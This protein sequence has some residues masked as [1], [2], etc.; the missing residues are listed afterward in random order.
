MLIPNLRQFCDSGYAACSSFDVASPCPWKEK[1]AKQDPCACFLASLKKTWRESEKSS[2][3]LKHGELV[4][5]VWLCRNS[6]TYHCFMTWNGNMFSNALS[7]WEGFRNTTNLLFTLPTKLVADCLAVSLR[8]KSIRGLQPGHV[9]DPMWD[10]LPRCSFV[11]PLNMF[12]SCCLLLR[13]F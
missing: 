7:Q 9:N 2:K 5:I 13:F 11:L 3:I 8:P 6:I 1:A 10:C 12:V 4:E